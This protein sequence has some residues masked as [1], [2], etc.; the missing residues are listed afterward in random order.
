MSD[1]PRPGPD[2]R[3][4][5]GLTAAAP[6]AAALLVWLALDWSGGRV[7][8]AASARA[9]VAEAQDLAER[10]RAAEAGPSGEPAGDL[11]PAGSAGGVLARIEAAAEGLGDGS[12]LQA[13]TGLSLG[14][15]GGEAVEVRLDGLTLA[16]TLT[17]LDRLA[18]LA[19][20]LP[21]RRLSL[22]PS[23]D[24]NGRSWSVALTVPA[25]G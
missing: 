18:A 9:G 25:G 8:A 4:R 21:A 10:L 11:E 13:T 15:G 7:D 6:L 5:A 3:L 22:E 23:G 19:P 1:P 14:G 16:D 12:P 24:P 2:P 17:L 20:P